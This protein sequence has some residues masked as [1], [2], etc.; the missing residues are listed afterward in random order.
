MSSLLRV[1]IAS[2]PKQATFRKNG[3]LRRCAPAMT[4]DAS[5][6]GNTIFEKIA[7]TIGQRQ[8]DQN[9]D[10]PFRTSFQCSVAAFKTSSSPISTSA[11]T[12]GLATDR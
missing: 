10:K 11:P 9:D 3:L 5:F 6:S 4:G 8:N 7:H 1:V 12:S 2:G